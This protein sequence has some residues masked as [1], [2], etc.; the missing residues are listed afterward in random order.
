MRIG[1]III[2]AVLILVIFRAL[3]THFVCPKCGE[4]FKISIFKYIFTIHLLGKRM[5][6]CPNCGH[7]EFFI[8]KWDKK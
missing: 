3:K 6:K 1:W 2:I 7:I 8:P 4:N 5:A